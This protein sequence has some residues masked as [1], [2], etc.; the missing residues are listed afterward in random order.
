[1]KTEPSLKLNIVCHSWL[2]WFWDKDSSHLVL[3]LMYSFGTLSMS[4]RD[5]PPTAKLIDAQHHSQS[6][7]T[8][9][10]LLI[11]CMDNPY[12]MKLQA[13]LEKLN[14]RYDANPK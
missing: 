9:I 11:D 4:M 5:L 8:L 6:L 13:V 2:I 3:T 12:V 14:K 10:Y 1:M 7:A